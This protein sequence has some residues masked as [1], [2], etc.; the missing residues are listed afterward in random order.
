MQSP[1][2]LSGLLDAWLALI[3]LLFL[4]VEFFCAN[5][6]GF[7]MNDCFISFISQLDS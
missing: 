1:V 4:G 3:T 2:D 6:G 5:S 7:H